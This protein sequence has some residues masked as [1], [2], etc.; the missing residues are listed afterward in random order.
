MAPSLP[1]AT[2]CCEVDLRQPLSLP[3]AW[4]VTSGVVAES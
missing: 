4:Q 3:Y 1:A 2:P